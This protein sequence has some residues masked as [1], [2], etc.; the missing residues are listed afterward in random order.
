M[1]HFENFIENGR[2]GP[3]PYWAAYMVAQPVGGLFA[4]C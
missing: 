1:K 4:P 2:N 3:N